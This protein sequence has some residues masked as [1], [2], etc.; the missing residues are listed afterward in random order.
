MGKVAFRVGALVQGGEAM[1]F[2]LPIKPVSKGRPRFWNGH[3]VTDA[4]TRAFEKAARTLMQLECNRAGWKPYSEPCVLDLTFQLARPKS[5]KR[6]LPSVKP[7][8]DNYIKAI[9]DSA[10]GI[11]FTDDALICELH[12]VKVYDEPE[13]IWI[14]IYPVG[15]EPF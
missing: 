5:V 1:K 12:A 8:L 15:N 2:F 13:G 4:K 10:N 6:E 3:A 14:S 9:S 7:D 11:L